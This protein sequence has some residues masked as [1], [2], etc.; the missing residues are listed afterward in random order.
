MALSVCGLIPEAEAA[1]RWLV[2]NPTPRRQLVQL[3]PGGRGQGSATRHQRVRL[4][5]GRCLAPPPH[6]RRCGV[7]GRVVADHSTRHRLHPAVAT[8]R[9]LGPVV[10]R[11]LGSHR[12]IRPLD[13][14]LLDLPL[15]AVRRR[16]GGMPGQG[17]PG[18]GVGSGPAR[19]RRGAPPLRLR[20]EGGVRHGLVLPGPFRSV[21]GRGR[22]TS[23]GRGLGH[24]RHGG[25]RGAV[26]LDGGLGDG[27]RDGRVRPGPRRTRA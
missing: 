18:L 16:R 7:P 11:S 10:P 21:G 23:P 14:L 24:L 15:L 2:D 8:A 3:L 4:P 12:G 5:R 26:R 22:P 9:R 17:P 25:A 27:G 13:G 6:H 1:Y 19:S 20:S